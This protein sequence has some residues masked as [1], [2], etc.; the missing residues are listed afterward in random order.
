MANEEKVRYAPARPVINVRAIGR[1]VSFGD[2][3]YYL[4][5]TWP[6]WRFFALLA[7]AWLT[8]NAGFAL[9]YALSPG[10]V[11]G[12]KSFVDLYFFSVQTMA[13]IGYGVM[14]PATYYAHV[15]VTLQALVGIMG[16]ALV[17]GVTFAKFARPSAKVLFS[18]NAVIAPR[19]G[20]P[21]LCFRVVNWRHNII[22]EAQLRVLILTR[23][24][25]REGHTM[26][27][28]VDLPLV[29]DRSAIFFLAWQV[30]HRIDEES[31]IVKLGG[32][33][34][35]KSQGVE[36]LLTLSGTDDTLAQTVHARH[37]YSWDEVVAGH[38]FA[39]VLR[40]EPDGTRVMDYRN[41]HALVPISWPADAGST[42]DASSPS[43]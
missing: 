30:M 21:H 27:R 25:T 42:S 6:W 15:L 7:G 24:T 29:R 9:L 23:E 16:V 32:V 33:E 18:K 13:T 40:T 4:L 34:A 35:L 1:A 8:S 20:V 41:M 37:R 17:T 22:A 19:D 31:P 2:D 12:A 36:L 3:A 10:C 5:L 11:S 39:D 38:H 14:A 26:L 28:Q 43:S